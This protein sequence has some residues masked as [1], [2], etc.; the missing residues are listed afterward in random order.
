MLL[1][2]VL[3]HFFL[4]LGAWGYF[5]Q[6]LG[7]ATISCECDTV[8]PSAEHVCEPHVQK[9]RTA[10]KLDRVQERASTSQCLQNLL[11]LEVQL[12]A[13]ASLAAW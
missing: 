12:R 9:H 11:Q 4:Y 6:T 8:L 2:C 13:S 10:R 7:C 5:V 3:Y 1:H